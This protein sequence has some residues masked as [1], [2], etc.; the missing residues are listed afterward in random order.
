MFGVTHAKRSSYFAESLRKL[1]AEQH[2]KTPQRQIALQ[3]GIP[4]SAFNKLRNKGIGSEEHICLILDYFLKI[5]RRR[6]QE[7]LAARRAELSEGKAAEIWNN[8]KYAF[9]DEDEYLAELCPIPMERA[10]ACTHC[11][12]AIKEIVELAKKNGINHIGGL[13]CIDIWKFRDF[14]DSVMQ[15]FGPENAK[16]ILSQKCEKFPPALLFEFS[17]EEDACN[18]VN[19]FN[20]KGKLLF[21]LPHII[22]GDYIFTAG[23]VI[24]N[25]INNGGVEILYS[26]E[27]TYELTCDGKTSSALLEACSALLIYDARVNH[28]IKL[29]NFDK[30]RLL[31]VRYYPT[32]RF[33]KPGK[34][35]T[36]TKH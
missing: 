12:V 35:K 29:V 10:F 23:G 31:M 8:F 9:I 3:L 20:C 11:G 22:F 18:Y 25:H 2:P 17:E 34:R 16:A 19:L 36:E 24:K 33:L 5:R 28:E 32:K 30:G 27:G 15:K 13:K 6:I 4:V 14:Y 7:M 26:L 21:G 1:I